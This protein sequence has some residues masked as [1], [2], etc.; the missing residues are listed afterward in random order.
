MRAEYE[1]KGTQRSTAI[2]YE[3]RED[4]SSGPPVRFM[5][6]ER[7]PCP[8]SQPYSLTL[9]LESVDPLRDI[10]RYRVIAGATNS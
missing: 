4:G 2:W 6:R 10:A 3:K 1:Y 5:V 7:D 9:E 8:N